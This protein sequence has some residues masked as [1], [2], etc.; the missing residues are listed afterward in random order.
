VYELIGNDFGKSF[1]IKLLKKDNEQARFVVLENKDESNISL[2]FTENH[3]YEFED[4][5]LLDPKR[6]AWRIKPTRPESD[7]IIKKKCLDMVTYIIDYFEIINKKEQGYNYYETPI[8][9]SPFTF[10]NGGIGLA[11]SENLPTEWEKTFYNHDDAVKAHG[12]LSGPFNDQEFPSGMETYAEGYIK[13]LKGVK[14]NL[15]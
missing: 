7:A 6:N 10:Y 13:F 2:F 14:I 1:K 4:I 3:R 15:E 5:D 8:F 11:R 12:L 9:Q